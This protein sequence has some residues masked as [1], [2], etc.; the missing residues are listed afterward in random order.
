[1]RARVLAQVPYLYTPRLVAADEFSLI[2][3]DHNVV[4]WRLVDVI[5]L[6]HCG[7]GISMVPHTRRVEDWVIAEQPLLLDERKQCRGVRTA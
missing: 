2:G 1:M 5:P 7:S 6:H 3:V 4:H